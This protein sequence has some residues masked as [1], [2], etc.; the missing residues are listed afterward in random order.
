MVFLKKSLKW[1]SVARKKR[2]SLI[3][4]RGRREEFKFTTNENHDK[5]HNLNWMHRAWRFCSCQSEISAWF[6]FGLFDA[7]SHVCRCAAKRNIKWCLKKTSPVEI[8]QNKKPEC[9]HARKIFLR[10]QWSS[11]GGWKI[12]F[13]FLTWNFFWSR[14]IN[15]NSSAVTREMNEIGIFS[16]FFFG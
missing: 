7:V 12:E 11:R 1:L 6:P 14:P 5:F 2:N 15:Q 3:S 8:H 16:L 13:N 4:I 9:R 10:T